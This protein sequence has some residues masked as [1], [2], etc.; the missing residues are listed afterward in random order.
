M[1]DQPQS[2]SSHER[3]TQEQREESN[4]SKQNALCMFPTVYRIEADIEMKKKPFNYRAYLPDAKTSRKKEKWQNEENRAGKELYFWNAPGGIWCHVED[5]TKPC[6]SQCIAS[7]PCWIKA[8]LPPHR[9]SDDNYPLHPCTLQGASLKVLV[10][11]F[12]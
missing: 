1:L 9:H 4:F 3:P 11:A 12:A 2:R 10:L 8:S 5:E 6:H 7:V